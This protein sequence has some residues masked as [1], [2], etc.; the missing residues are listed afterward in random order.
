MEP[1]ISPSSASMELMFHMTSFIPTRIKA[2]I[3]ALDNPKLCHAKLLGWRA[4]AGLVI[5][6]KMSGK[7]I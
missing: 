3:I 7:N 6:L 5:L 4:V 2:E 1:S